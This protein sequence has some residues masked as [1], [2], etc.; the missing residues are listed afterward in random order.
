MS[1]CVTDATE[2]TAFEKAG[3]SFRVA[4]DELI[5]TAN[6][7]FNKKVNEILS[8]QGLIL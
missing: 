5:R 2:R 4:T 8:S 3:M 7:P 1:Q 6:H